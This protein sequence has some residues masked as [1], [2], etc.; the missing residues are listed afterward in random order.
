MPRIHHSDVVL[1]VLF[2]IF[3]A[4]WITFVVMGL[5]R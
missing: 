2:V 3:A 1:G 4:C 5:S